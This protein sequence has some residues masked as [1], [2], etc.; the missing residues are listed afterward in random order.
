MDHDPKCEGGQSELTL[1]LRIL[2]R[3]LCP[4]KRQIEDV[5]PREMEPTRPQKAVLSAKQTLALPAET[6]TGI[7]EHTSINQGSLYRADHFLAI[8]MLPL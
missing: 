8:E 5:V 4:T 2:L 1:R 6:A 7:M 3:S